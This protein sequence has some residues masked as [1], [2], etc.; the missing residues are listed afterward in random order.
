MKF[1]FIKNKGDKSRLEIAFENE[2]DLEMFIEMVGIGYMLMRNEKKVSNSNKELFG[3]LFGYL[4]SKDP[5]LEERMNQ[6]WGH[7]DDR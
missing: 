7:V 3:S 6:W 5:G 4:V 2:S 1:D